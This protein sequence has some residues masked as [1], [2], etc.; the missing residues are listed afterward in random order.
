M[1]SEFEKKLKCKELLSELTFCEET[2]SYS[3]DILPTNLATI[4]GAYWAWEK[5]Q[6]EV[7]ELQKSIQ[8]LIKSW[9]DLKIKGIAPEHR[10]YEKA[11]N[12]CANELEQAL[13][14]G[15]E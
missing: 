8:E 4:N 14:G 1:R 12:D 11:L 6:T 7:D 9:R 2:K 10:A 3:G 5:R 13:K 15:G